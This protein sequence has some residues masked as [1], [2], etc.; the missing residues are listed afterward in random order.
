M[1]PD[2]TKPPAA[3]AAAAAPSPVTTSTKPGQPSIDVTKTPSSA[4]VTQVA[5][6]NAY[7]ADVE[8]LVQR[9]KAY[10]QG[11]TAGQNTLMA[12][13][14]FTY[15]NEPTGGLKAAFP[16]DEQAA[17]IQGDAGRLLRQYENAIGGMRA[18]SGPQ[19]Q[20]ALA[21]VHGGDALSNPN[22]HINLANVAAAMRR[23]LAAHGEAAQKAH[24]T[25]IY[26]PAPAAGGGGDFNAW[27]RGQQGR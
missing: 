26:T 15:R 5:K 22:A 11:R 25:D 10:Q 21:E 14:N 2:F 8:N 24:H 9:L 17:G 7:I 1:P 12:L 13:R 23:E 4:D 19:I 20:A 16:L 6:A 27:K 18:V 3:P